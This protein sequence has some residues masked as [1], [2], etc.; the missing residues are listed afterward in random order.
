LLLGGNSI[1]A[2]YSL[3]ALQELIITP[4]YLCIKVLALCGDTNRT[5]KE[6]DPYQEARQI[7]QGK[8]DFATNNNFIDLVYTGLKPKYDFK[9]LVA[10]AVKKT[11][12]V[13][14][15]ADFHTDPWYVP[16]ATAAEMK[17]T[18]ARVRS[19]LAPS[20][21]LRVHVTSRW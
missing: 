20:A 7:I 3:N 4:D 12:T 17:H 21:H 8:P 11:I 6:I 15:L 13:V 5:Y 19:R 16:G 18:M 14:H 2:N 1:V 10:G 9:K